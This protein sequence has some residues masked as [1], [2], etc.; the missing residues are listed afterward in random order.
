[1][2]MKQSSEPGDLLSTKI[3]EGPAA[4]DICR[5]EGVASNL[6]AGC[7]RAWKWVASCVALGRWRAVCESKFCP[8]AH[9]QVP[10][11]E[12]FGIQGSFVPV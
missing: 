9:L 8:L 5:S 6:M 10:G 1:M 3:I 2:E 7:S 4:Y 12:M 11:T